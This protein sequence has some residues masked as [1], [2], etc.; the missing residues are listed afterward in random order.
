MILVI[1]YY[2]ECAP[3]QILL[4]TVFVTPQHIWND[5]YT[6]LSFGPTNTMNLEKNGYIHNKLDCVTQVGQ[7]EDQS[8]SPL[9]QALYGFLQQDT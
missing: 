6:V 7:F 1:P 5:K 3:S 2:V 8:F 9:I 4:S